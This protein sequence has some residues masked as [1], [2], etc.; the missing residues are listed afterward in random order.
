MGD[1]FSGGGH[2]NPFDTAAMVPARES[3]HSFSAARMKAWVST[4]CRPPGLMTGTASSLPASA[5]LGPRRGMTPTTIPQCTVLAS[6]DGA[7]A[8]NGPIESATARARGARLIR[9][10]RHAWLRPRLPRD[11]N[12][13]RSGMYLNVA[14]NNAEY[15]V[16]FC[17]PDLPLSAREATM[18]AI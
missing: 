17:R 9:R 8:G 14:G 4:A 16:I 5:A 15:S 2:A 7:F 11:E 3:G 13:S 18:P 1:A 6:L 10:V 12:M